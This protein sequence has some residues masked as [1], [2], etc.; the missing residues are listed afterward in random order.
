M[1][2]KEGRK[3]KKGCCFSHRIE[4]KYRRLRTLLFSLPYN[5]AIEKR[6]STGACVPYYSPFPQQQQ[7]NQPPN[8]TNQPSY[9]KE[10]KY[11]RLRTLLFSLPHNKIDRSINL[12]FSHSASISVL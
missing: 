6:E 9:R 8:Q 7:P 1:T 10:R 3:E 11:R 4:R 12:L 2:K 5:Q